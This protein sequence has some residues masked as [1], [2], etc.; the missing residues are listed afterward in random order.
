MQEEFEMLMEGKELPPLTL[1][2]DKTP[3][4]EETV[5]EEKEEVKAEEKESTEVSEKEEK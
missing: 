1:A 3:S 4:H 2:K 5:S